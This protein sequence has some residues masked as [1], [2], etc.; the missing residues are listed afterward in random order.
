MAQK[1]ASV[2][3][4][5]TVRY[6]LQ[7]ALAPVSGDVV[8]NIDGKRY[9]KGSFKLDGRVFTST[10][11]LT[12]ADGSMLMPEHTEKGDLPAQG[13][14]LMPQGLEVIAPALLPAAGQ[15]EDIVFLEFPAKLD[16]MVTVDAGC[17]LTRT[18]QPDGSVKFQLN[19]STG[20]PVWQLVLDSKAVIKEGTFFE[21]KFVPTTQTEATKPVT[22]N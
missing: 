5:S 4:D 14:V 19:K 11:S 10:S 16:S 7:P 18:D 13:L 15:R 2:G 22:A 1:D 20:Q 8:T 17:R 6:A 9:L 12:N 21:T 3:Y